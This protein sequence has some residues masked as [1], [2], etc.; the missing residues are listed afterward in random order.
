MVASVLPRG[1]GGNPF[2]SLGLLTGYRI[3]WSMPA[4]QRSSPKDSTGKK[5]TLRTNDSPTV[6]ASR[7]PVQSSPGGNV[8][9]TMEALQFAKEDSAK[10][11]MAEELL[12]RKLGLGQG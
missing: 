3:G 1:A 9:A 5:V 11:K 12:R 8:R 10:R 2:P 4:P 6:S 7:S